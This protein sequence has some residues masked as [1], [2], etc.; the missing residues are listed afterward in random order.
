M[1]GVTYWQIMIRK[2][3][4]VEMQT[5][6]DPYTQNCFIWKCDPN[7]SVEGEACTGD[8]EK[9]IWYYNIIK[10]NVSRIPV[11][12]P[13]DESCQS[14]VCGENEL[15]CEQIFCDDK[16]KV[17]QKVEC[18]DPVKYTEEN[19]IEEEDGDAVCDPESDEE[20]TTNATEDENTTENSDLE[21][22]TSGIENESAPK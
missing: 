16:T 8:A 20:C 1:V 7:S 15:E 4:I 14:S 19:P 11:C 6:C 3:F 22:P 21:Q 2:N 18:N 10:R 13:N 17:E 9:D 12:D 5:D